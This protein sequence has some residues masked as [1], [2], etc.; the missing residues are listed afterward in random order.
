M[1]RC[2]S[3]AGRPIAA[4]PSTGAPRAGGTLPTWWLRRPFRLDVN[5]WPKKPR[6]SPPGATAA[7]M[8]WSLSTVR[9]P[10]C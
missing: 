4:G 10:R 5:C 8:S 1:V 3:D 9:D 7:R 6:T 2:G